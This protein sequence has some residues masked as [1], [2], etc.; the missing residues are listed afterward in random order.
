MIELL[1]LAHRVHIPYPN[2]SIC[3]GRS[4][5]RQLG[6]KLIHITKLSSTVSPW[7]TSLD[8]I[9]E[10]GSSPA[11]SC[12]LLRRFDNSCIDF[13]SQSRI[14]LPAQVDMILL[15]SEKAILLAL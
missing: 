2:D 13:E 10:D 14:L 9:S 6:E 8:V 7:L 3:G 4:N 12:A 15:S 5:L 1:Y 11:I